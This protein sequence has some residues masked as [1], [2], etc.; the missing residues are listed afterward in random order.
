MI[1]NTTTDVV[2]IM[3]VLVRR[4]DAGLARRAALNAAH[5]ME[6]NRSRRID[7]VRTMRDLA[8]IPSADLRTA[9]QPRRASN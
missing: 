5:S 7:D 4:A 1:V 3:G 6:V 8:R 2:R 9:A